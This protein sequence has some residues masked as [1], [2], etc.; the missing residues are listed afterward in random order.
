MMN[1]NKFVTF[2]AAGA[3]LAA[4]ILLPSSR[5]MAAQSASPVAA[6][7]E[8]FPLP[9][10]NADDIEEMSEQ[11]F[12]TD[13]A[14][15]S[16]ALVDLTDGKVIAGHRQDTQM[17]PASMTKIMTLLT[18]C[19]QLEPIDLSDTV[20]I[21]DDILNYASDHDLSTI[22]FASGE[23][24][25]VQDLLYAT[26]LPS[27]A[28]GALALGR[29]I[30][31]SDML[32]VRMMNEKAVALGLTNTHFT[33]DIGLY[34]TTHFSTPKD[35]AAIL[36]A[37]SRNPLAWKIL[38]SRRY[39]TIPTT[40]HTS[41]I[42]VTNRFF[43]RMRYVPTPGTTLSAKTGFVTESGFCAASYFVSDSGRHYILVT[44][45]ST[46]SDQC[47]ADHGIIYSHYRR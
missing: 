31:G 13:V 25:T 39:T 29:Y 26:I 15:T 18:A 40:L 22:G 44:G 16:A 6:D 1:F 30:A 33:N 11:D 42:T 23:T 27:G 10:P 8:S 38:S 45:G 3:L 14:S 4:G 34:D 35:M 19:D 7:S 17:V 36:Y 41:G 24:V 43:E 5:S 21:T 37:A 46:S 2:F 12:W 9:F 32:F 47:A 28:D 20:T